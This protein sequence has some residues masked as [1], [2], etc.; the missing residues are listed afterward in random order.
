MKPEVR[1]F[2]VYP[3]VV[4]VG[5]EAE[6]NI[7]PLFKHVRFGEAQTLNVEYL[8]CNSMQPDGNYA[9]VENFAGVPFRLE[10]GTLAVK[11]FFPGESEYCIRV[12]V[13][14]DGKSVI[15]GDFMV[16]ALE[17]DLFELRPFKGDFHLHSNCSDGREA[18]DY[19]AA[20]CRRIGFDFM[21]LT[22]HHRYEPSLEACAAMTELETDLKCYPGEEVHA[23]DNNVHIINFGGSFSVNKLF[24][25][26]EA[27]YRSEVAER[28]AAMPEVPEDIRFTLAASEWCYDKIRE[29][30]GLCIFCHPY[31]MPGQRYHISE[32]VITWMF[33]RQKFDAFE[34]LGGFFKH[35]LESNNLQVARYNDERAAGR[36]IPIVGASDSHGCDHDL[37]GWYYS[38]VLARSSA[39]EDLK[40]GVKQ[41]N[42]VAIEAVESESYRVYGPFRQVRYVR[43][44][45][46]EF[47]PLH[48]AVCLEEGLL[49]LKALGGMNNAAEQLKA[50]KGRTAEMLK[51]YWLEQ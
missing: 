20:S 12:S 31:W 43:F 11:L 28:A 38:V 18:P 46:R 47:F 10:N 41:L 34:L 19:V 6:I 4:P 16:Y 51:K 1:Y 13:Q 2:D 50:L 24:R 32:G 14:R 37:F 23:P 26:D 39:L 30:G 40:D 48:D 44:L 42:S 15:V 45:M 17:S 25:E 49:M 8:C 33:R 7:K 5:R 35:Q 21:A 27:R 9:P 29:G 22:D 36:R 3:K